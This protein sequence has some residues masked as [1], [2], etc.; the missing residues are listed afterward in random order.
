MMTLFQPALKGLDAGIGR[1]E[2][3]LLVAGAIYLFIY[4]LG[5]FGGGATQLSNKYTWRHYY[6]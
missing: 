3:V 1:V 5:S 4:L 2:S 6:L